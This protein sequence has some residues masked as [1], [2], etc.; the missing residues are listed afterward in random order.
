MSEPTTAALS[1]RF[2]LYDA[3]GQMVAT[4]DS[5]A[6]VRDLHGRFVEA[7]DP[8]EDVDPDVEREYRESLLAACQMVRR[9]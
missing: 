6:R 3:A 5:D 2:P 8:G 1:V 9:V 7:R 4:I